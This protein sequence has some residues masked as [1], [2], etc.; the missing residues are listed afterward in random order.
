MPTRRMR[1]A[2]CCRACDNFSKAMMNAATDARLCTNCESAAGAPPAPPAPQQQQQQQ[3]RQPPPP[4]QDIPEPD[5][6]Y[7]QPVNDIREVDDSAPLTTEQVEHEVRD[8]AD[9][10]DGEGKYYPLSLWAGGLFI[11]RGKD[12]DTAP[13]LTFDPAKDGFVHYT[14]GFETELHGQYML[15]EEGAG[16]EVRWRN[17]RRWEGDN[18]NLKANDE[19]IDDVEVIAISTDGKAVLRGQDEEWIWAA[20]P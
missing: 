9:A 7:R 1:C 2:G 18:N 11:P 14:D 17:L 12:P 20:E 4:Q 15:I 10:T 8:V 19:K 3:L 6:P 5:S 13:Q 16:C